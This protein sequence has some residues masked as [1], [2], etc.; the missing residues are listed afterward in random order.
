MFSS[1]FV[2]YKKNRVGKWVKVIDIDK[3]FSGT[4]DN[5]DDITW[6]DYLI[7]PED[8]DSFNMDIDGQNYLI[9]KLEGIGQYSKRSKKVTFGELP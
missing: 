5:T 9:V 8:S 2:V 1:A 7:V 6:L 4:F 3:E